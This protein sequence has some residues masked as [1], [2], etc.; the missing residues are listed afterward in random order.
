[1]AVPIGRQP[2]PSAAAVAQAPSV[3]A[4]RPG[5]EIASPMSVAASP[6]SQASAWIFLVL[7][8]L[9]VLSRIF[10]TNSLAGE[11][12]SDE[13][14]YAVHARDLARA[15]VIGQTP[16]IAN[17]G[18]EGRLAALESAAL[19]LLLPWDPLTIGRTV[20]ALLNAL[21]IPLTFVLARQVGLTRAAAAAAALLL[22]AV[23]QFQELAWR[24]WT[25]SQATLLSLAYLA[26]LVSFTRRPSLASSVVAL[27]AL[28]GLVATKESAAITFAPF[29]SVALIPLARRFT[30]SGRSRALLALVVVGLV[31]AALA[32]VLV[33]GQRTLA[34]N[35]L[36]Q[37]TF[38]AGPLI[39]SSVGEAI[40]RLPEYSDQ[41]TRIVGVRELGSGFLWAI[42]VGY[43]WL[44]AQA[45]VGL[46]SVRRA[47]TAWL[48]GWAVA[49]L[50][51]PAGISLALR[52]LALLKLG[53]V[54]VL[55]AAAGLLV[56]IGTVELSLRGVRPGGWGLALLGLV[57][58]AVLAER[59]IIVAT[60]TVSQA[61]L[62][63]R[64]LMPIV[65]LYAV[66]AGAGLWAAGGAFGLLMPSMRG[67]RGACAVLMCLML[68]VFWSPLLRERLSRESL[69]GRVADRGADAETPQGLRVE[70]LVEAEGWLKAN[71]QPG[72]LI[73]TGIPRHLAWYADL[74]VDGMTNLIDLNSQPRTEEQRRQY[75]LERVGPRGVHYV[76]DFNVNWT[77]PAG[78]PAR[79]WRQ[80][81]ETL[82]GR[83]NLEV[84]YLKRD[85][86]DNPVFYVIRNYGYAYAP[87]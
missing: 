40:P 43:V 67:A 45:L 78:E 5:E 6:F 81:F 72:D 42:V 49:A 18:S 23:P 77:D 84:A 10:T 80:T 9:A 24:F 75:I 3:S 61:A 17:V 22:L 25:D 12:T 63:F 46:L 39:L 87:R 28:A 59:L 37:K 15:W 69:V 35:P 14:L 11:P 30:R 68:I 70:T 79:Q 65:P 48:L 31:I 21:C 58:L 44:L 32:L 62:T 47:A 4:P 19:S 2:W 56:A 34:A 71:L 27:L 38:G 51:L 82:A 86:F 54:W 33:L 8:V 57:V 26:A 60:P 85:R 73:L 36:L 83:P 76:I 29:L 7:L 64:S 1:M 16:S 41:L 13:Y 66:L 55:L 52:D 53:D 20:Q 74:G 50:V